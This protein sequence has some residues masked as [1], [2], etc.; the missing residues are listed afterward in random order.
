MMR[1]Q[2]VE[3][4]VNEIMSKV[5][6]SDNGYE[7][8]KLQRLKTAKA[9]KQWFHVSYGEDDSILRRKAIRLVNL[10]NLGKNVDALAKN[11]LIQVRMIDHISNEDEAM[12]QLQLLKQRIFIMIHE[13]IMADT[14]DK[15]VAAFMSCGFPNIDTS[16]SRK[17]NKISK[18]PPIKGFQFSNLGK[19]VELKAR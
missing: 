1:Y 17:E 2:L 5:K 8:S 4:R 10:Y 3:K 12:F 19:Q 15:L 16:V 14:D 6:V 13:F 11:I 7:A 9:I 18:N